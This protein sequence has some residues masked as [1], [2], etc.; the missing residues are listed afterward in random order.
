MIMDPFPPHQVG[1]IRDTLTFLVTSRTGVAKSCTVS[2]LL[3]LQLHHCK[4]NAIAIFS[5]IICRMGLIRRGNWPRPLLFPTTFAF[6][7]GI[8]NTINLSRHIGTLV[9]LVQSRHE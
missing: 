5:V 6:S 3:P 1:S 9:W 2:K 8:R 4:E 7:D